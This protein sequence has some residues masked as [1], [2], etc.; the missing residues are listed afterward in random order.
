MI[1]FIKVMM[2][3]MTGLLYGAKEM[4]HQ[5]ILIKEQAYRWKLYI[6]GVICILEA[7]NLPY[8]RI[9]MRLVLLLAII[10]LV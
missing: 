5:I 6:G 8:P 9:R 2:E 4:R 10:K 7:L 3:G 1:F